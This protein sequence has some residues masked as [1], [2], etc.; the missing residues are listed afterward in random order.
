MKGWWWED[1]G[2]RLVRLGHALVLMGKER[3]KIMMMVVV[4]V[5]VMKRERERFTNSQQQQQ[6]Q[7]QQQRGNQTRRGQ[8]RFEEI[9]SI[10]VLSRRNVER[11]DGWSRQ[12]KKRAK[13]I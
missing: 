5:V 3:E 11:A 6:Q 4:V 1:E 7:Q 12:K 8:G 2:R 10:P 9:P 13:T